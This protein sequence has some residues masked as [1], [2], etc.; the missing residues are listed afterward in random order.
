VGLKTGANIWLSVLSSI[1][2]P[3]ILATLHNWR[4]SSDNLSLAIAFDLEIYNVFFNFS[5]LD[6]CTAL[7]SSFVNEL[8]ILC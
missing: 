1:V 5:I 2:Q 6:F 8:N 7:S 4:S 3:N